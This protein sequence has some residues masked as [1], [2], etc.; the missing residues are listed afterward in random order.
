M[1]MTHYMELLS[2][3]QPWNL[4]V[5]MAIPVILAETLAISELYL[6][7]TRKTTGK[8]KTISRISGIVA[9]LY[10]TAIFLYLFKTAVVPLTIDGGWRGAADIIAVG[11]YLLGVVPLAGIALLELQLIYKKASQH[12]KRMLHAGFIGAFLVVAH[13]A[14]IFG[15]LNP[16]KLGWSGSTATTTATAADMSM[17]QMTNNLRGQSADNFDRRFLS[18]MIVHH[19]GAIEMANLAEKQAKHQELKDLAQNIIQA[20]EAEILQ[21]QQWQALWG[22]TSSGNN[23]HGHSMPGM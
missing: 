2:T 18:E 6:L 8:I 15:M 19:Q 10:F 9:G 16:S 5:Y 13:V 11:M 12:K 22:Y 17:S 23:D 14:M 7:F 4:I 20:Q 21:M 3:N 1:E